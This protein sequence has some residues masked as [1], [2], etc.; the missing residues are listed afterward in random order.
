V[1]LLASDAEIGSDTPKINPFPSSQTSPAKVH[2]VLPGS[3][4]SAKD[5]YLP[6]PQREMLYNKLAK[7][8]PGY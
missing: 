1:K 7:Q 6:I 8:N 2:F 5:M 4:I 3:N